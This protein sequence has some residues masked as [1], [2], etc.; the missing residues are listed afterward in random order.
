M[1]ESGESGESLRPPL[2]TY[3]RPVYL[4]I[5]GDE[6]AFDFFAM[7]VIFAIG[8][9]FVHGYIFA[10]SSWRTTDER[11]AT[12]ITFLIFLGIPAALFLGVAAYRRRLE[13]KSRA[14]LGEIEA[15][16]RGMDASSPVHH[17]TVTQATEAVLRLRLAHR[18]PRWFRRARIELDA[19]REAF[20]SRGLP[21]PRF[22]IEEKYEVGVRGIPRIEGLLEPEPIGSL[23]DRRKLW[24][25]LV[26]LVFVT[27]V[28]ASCS[29]NWWIGAP[30]LVGLVGATLAIARVARAKGFDF[31]P[32]K[33]PI[34]GPGGL[35]DPRGRVWS[36]PHALTLITRQS[37]ALQVDLIAGPDRIRLT[38]S[39]PKD[40]G[41]VTFWARWSHPHPRPELLRLS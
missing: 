33:T 3:V 26:S 14:R 32:Q 16:R 39:S 7:G 20:E 1:R 19:W 2:T 27:F 41:F 35:A 38:Y 24:S 4:R 10:S 25:D 31:F 6:R 36:A 34:A 17:D 15:A 29:L 23:G 37:G 11:I 22:V 28:V 13:V 12:A 30:Y 40:P 21:A 8:L 18:R 9:F 5:P